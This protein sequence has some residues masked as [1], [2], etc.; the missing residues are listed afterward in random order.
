MPVDVTPGLQPQP[1]D[2]QTLQTKPRPTA[3]ITGG[4]RRIGRAISIALA[5]AGYDVAITYRESSSEA[6]EVARSIQS[7]G[8]QSLALKMDQRSEPS[9]RQAIAEMAENWG[10]LDLLINNAAIIEKA[11]LDE[12]TLEDWDRVF[13]SNTRG[14]FLV[15]RECLPHLKAANGRIVN[16]GSLG[17]ASHWP[18]HAHYCASKAALHSLTLTMAKAL[19]PQISVNCVAPGY[20]EMPENGQERAVAPAFAART[21]MGRNGT[22]DEVAAAVLFFAQGPHFITGQI[23]TV[24][25]GLGL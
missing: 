2:P 18:Q 11:P 15:A 17:G 21:P 10:K 19:A 14:P 9:I 3:L 5:Q 1:L 6:A 7:T 22:A 24:D 4:A 8:V 23:L 16:L 25:G 13:E 20:I 12:I